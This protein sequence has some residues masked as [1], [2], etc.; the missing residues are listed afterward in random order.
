MLQGTFA[1]GF[2]NVC[3]QKQPL[4]ITILAP[5]SPAEGQGGLGDQGIGRE[6][7]GL[8]NA[9]WVLGWSFRTMEGWEDTPPLWAC[10]MCAHTIRRA[11][12]QV[13]AA[14]IFR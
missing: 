4:F 6:D 8:E 14:G 11:G 10:S 2:L 9:G 1:K 7:D 5:H 12:K 13:S 3:S